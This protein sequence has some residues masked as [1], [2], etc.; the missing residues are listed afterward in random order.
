MSCWPW[1]RAT[2]RKKKAVQM[3]PPQ[4]LD[5][6]R[7]PLTPEMREDLRCAA[8]LAREARNRDL[9]DRLILLRSFSLGF[10]AHW[11]LPEDSET[12]SGIVH[13]LLE[14]TGALGRRK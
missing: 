1:F 5:Q 13:L 12:I 3:R 7:A 11:R 10:A 9:P 14:E 6:L 4:S 2:P 8:P